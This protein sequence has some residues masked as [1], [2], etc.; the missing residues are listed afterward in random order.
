MGNALDINLTGK[1]VIFRQSALSVPAEKHPYRVDG[2]F[3]ASP[4]TMGRALWGEFLSDGEECRMEG[5]MVE[6]LATPEEILDALDR[7]EP[8]T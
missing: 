2:G 3:G 8:T 5:Y 4:N 1:V 6:R 7:R